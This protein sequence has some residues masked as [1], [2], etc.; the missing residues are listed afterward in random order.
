MFCRRAV[1]YRLLGFPAVYRLSRTLL[2]PGSEAALGRL[3][4]REWGEPRAD[5]RILDVGCGPRSLL[6]DF[7]AT[8]FG[9]DLS[10]PYLKVF[11]DDGGH[12]ALASADRLPFA[13]SSFDSVWSF[14]L[15]HHL[16]DAVAAAAITEMIRVCRDGGRVVVF[17]G[18][19]PRRWWM[20]PIAYL[21]RRFDRGAFMRCQEA[22]Q[23]LFPDPDAW[24]FERS[25]SAYTG[26]ELVVAARRFESVAQRTEE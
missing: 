6:A 24:S 20:R 11:R 12:A 25:T 2:A 8:M 21:I 9:V 19:Y 23:T 26:L 7:G 5:A 15:L 1:I 4:H 13:G 17:D 22:L 3:A 16:P 10:R 14:G 18:V